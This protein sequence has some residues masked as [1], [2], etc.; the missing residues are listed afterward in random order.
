LIRW[1]KVWRDLWNDKM[2]TF[3]VVLS[4]TIGV[5]GVGVIGQSRYFLTK[6]MENSFSASNPANVT[7]LAETFDR[8]IASQIENMDNI[9]KLEIQNTLYGK[10]KSLSDRSNQGDWNSLKLISVSDFNK[11]SLNKLFLEKGNWPSTIQEIV[12]EEVSMNSLELQIGDDVII[13]H[14]NGTEVTFNISG[15]VFDPIRETPRI[16]GYVYAYTT[17]EAATSKNIA[18]NVN[19]LLLQANSKVDNYKLLEDLAVRVRD[20]LRLNGISVLTIDLI[21]PNKHWASDIVKS[22]GTILEC[23][24]VM[25]LFLGIGLIVNTI[26][27]IMI[28]QRRQIAV[29]KVIGAT[30]S[31]ILFLYM[32]YVFILGGIALVIGIPVSLWT[33]QMIIQKSLYLLNFSINLLNPSLKMIALQ[34][35]VALLIPMLVAFIPVFLQ[36]KLPI[37][38]AIN[39][40]DIHAFG[41]S[42]IDVFLK[43]VKHLPIPI[44]LSI[45]NTF[46]RKGRLLLTILTLSIGGAMV[47]SVLSVKN[48]I[49]TTV[50]R[51]MGYANYDI[52]Y[53]LLSF[54]KAK[55]IKEELLEYKEIKNTDTAIETFTTLV[56]K[57]HTKS[58]QLT[59]VGVNPA[60][61]FNRPLIVDGSWLSHEQ[62][63]EIVVNQLL[64]RNEKDMKIGDKITLNTNGKESSW[65]VMGFAVM[66]RRIDYFVPYKTLSSV[67]GISG[68]VNVLQLQ[69]N[70][71]E[72]LVLSKAGEGIREA[73]ASKGFV[74]SSPIITK[75]LVIREKSRNDIIVFLLLGMSGLV[76]IIAVLGLM[77]TMGL[78]VIER[79]REIGIMRSIGASDTNIWT[80][81]VVEA[82]VIGGISGCLSI[83]WA[84]PIGKALSD[85]IGETLFD[86]PLF[87]VYSLSHLFLWV[88]TT[89]VFSA[90]AC[91]LPAWRA[92]R[93]QVRDVLNYE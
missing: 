15:T 63:N 69:M 74:A 1:S 8:E 2:R 21:E 13:Q 27:A 72:Q 9:Q 28:S 59:V 16:S 11:L 47:L 89:V 73:L 43:R 32:R 50:E 65:K 78:N 85:H 55:E 25:G 10:V 20:S 23:F 80:I 45:R 49:Q 77:G 53:A 31:D 17:L 33:T 37:I 42:K 61:S 91:F 4:I 88:L 57:D 82:I 93:M 48:S 62:S 76:C 56:R 40:Q 38:H 75:D 79:S 92:S 90:L 30:T 35:V 58:M 66:P 83:L 3:L 14:P 84:Y 81:V 44:L 22:A 6:G 52:Q 36:I 86:M 24:G 39:G 19:T 71:P 67:L 70:K 34:T 46:R 87:Y 64:A 12:M 51:T 5:V 29:M 54:S 41:N 18:N 7:I 68:Q 26:T 60:T